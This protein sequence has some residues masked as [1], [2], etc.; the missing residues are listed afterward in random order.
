M[1]SMN[2]AFASSAIVVYTLAG[3]CTPL[4]LLLPVQSAGM[5]LMSM[6]GL[7]RSAWDDIKGS[8]YRGI[9]YMGVAYREFSSPE[10]NRTNYKK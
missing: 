5:P 4:I 9:V 1:F 3:S 10:L 8:L 6:V 7:V 2:T